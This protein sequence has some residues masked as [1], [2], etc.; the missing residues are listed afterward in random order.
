MFDLDGTLA[1]TMTLVPQAYADTIR[2]LG[3]PVVSPAEVVAAWHTGPT[4]AVL[5]HFIGR[6]VTSGDIECFYSAFD[7]LTEAVRPFP[8]IPGMLRSLRRQGYRL[9]I[10]THAT[11][12]AATM[13]LEAA[14]LGRF[15]LPLVGGEEVSE[16]KPAPEG[17][18]LACRRIS[19]APAAAAYVGDAEA[20]LQCAAAAGSLGI[21][22]RWGAPAAAVA[23]T[24]LRPHLTAQHPGDVAELL[25]VDRAAGGPAL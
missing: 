4:A 25:T 3:G 7:A 22:A 1:D 2:F 14:G 5:E 24:R 20:D 11:R 15:R 12:R 6:T 13:T 19:V 21:H 16:L 18:L 23:G 9:G 17:L 8:G 10:F